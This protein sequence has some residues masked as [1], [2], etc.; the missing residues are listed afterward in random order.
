MINS[1]LMQIFSS[2]IKSRKCVFYVLT[3]NMYYSYNYYWVEYFLFAPEST[4]CCAALRAAWWPPGGQQSPAPRA[5]LRVRDDVQAGR[6]PLLHHAGGHPGY[7]RLPGAWRPALCR[8]GVPLPGRDGRSA[9]GRG[10]SRRR[11]QLAG[12]NEQHHA[13]G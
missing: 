2:T 9:G 12:R 4:G 7:R 1:M 13:L 8:A 3:K 10:G 11:V 5:D 6:P